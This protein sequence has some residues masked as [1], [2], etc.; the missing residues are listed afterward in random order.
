MGCANLGSAARSPAEAQLQGR[1][2]ECL[3]TDRHGFF[4]CREAFIHIIDSMF[5]QHAT[6]LNVCR[7]IPRRQAYKV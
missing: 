3:L 2:E 1:L 7:E 4:S 6:W 5:D